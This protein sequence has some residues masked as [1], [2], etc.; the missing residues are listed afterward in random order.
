MQ[1][2]PQNLLAIENLLHH[3]ELKK[4]KWELIKMMTRTGQHQNLEPRFEICMLLLVVLAEL[5]DSE[6]I[7]QLK[8]EVTQE[9]GLI[10]PIQADRSNYVLALCSAYQGNYQE[11]L[12][13]C[14]LSLDDLLKFP[15][16]LSGKSTQVDQ[17][18]LTLAGRIACLVKLSRFK[19]AF[20]TLEHLDLIS[21]KS[22][23]VNAQIAVE[24]N[25]ADLLSRA[26]DQ[27]RSWHR[28]EKARELIRSQKS[29]LNHIKATIIAA[30]IL[31]RSGQPLL[32]LD[33]LR[34]ADSLCD[35]QELGFRSHRIHENKTRLEKIT[36]QK[37]DLSID[38]NYNFI[39]EKNL[40]R[41]DLGQQHLLHVLLS[42]LAMARGEPVSKSEICRIL[43]SVDYNPRLHDNKIYVSIKRL[44]NLVEPDPKNP[45]YVRRVKGGYC[46][47]NQ[48]QPF[49]LG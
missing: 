35:P 45:R 37:S 43:W 32:A 8:A 10:Y 23:S 46:L 27:T 4:A 15:E 47:E 42:C 22:S 3:C 17:L 16:L 19:E 7:A 20:G 26:G 24:L 48:S 39:H 9:T 44:R 25:A 21:K 28:M 49:K 36:T 34:H 30:E 38:P 18:V 11:S 5:Q 31:E 33:Y 2:T 29:L 40:G 13:Y 41:I 6:M 14:E 1:T 12:S